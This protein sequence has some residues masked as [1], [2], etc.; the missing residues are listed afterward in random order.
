VG[1]NKPELYAYGNSRGDRRM[2]SAAD[3]PVDCGQLG[4]LGA[5][6]AFPRLG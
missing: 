5:L 2:L 6:R 4:T 3:H 1:D